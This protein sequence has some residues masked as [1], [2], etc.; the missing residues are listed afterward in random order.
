MNNGNIKSSILSSGRTNNS[1]LSSKRGSK[2]PKD[3][4]KSNKVDISSS[5][6]TSLSGTQWYTAD[7]ENNTINALTPNGTP[8][9]ELR[10]EVSSIHE[11]DLKG[12]KIYI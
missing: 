8:V 4:R 11:T 10:Q 2:T 9:F 3:K 1:T 5:P 7:N 6:N 12:I